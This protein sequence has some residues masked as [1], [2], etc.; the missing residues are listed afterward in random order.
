MLK[1]CITNGRSFIWITSSSIGRNQ[2]GV[3]LGLDQQRCP[4]RA[5]HTG[6]HLKS[7]QDAQRLWTA[8]RVGLI[9]T[10]Q[11]QIFSQSQ[12][13]PNCI[14][15]H[16]M[17][18]SWNIWI[19]VNIMEMF[20]V[21]LAFSHLSRLLRCEHPL[22]YTISTRWRANKSWERKQTV[23]NHKIWPKRRCTITAWS[24]RCLPSGF[25]KRLEYS[26]NLVFY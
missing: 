15:G 23:T 20:R 2:S 6:R 25:C 4:R 19:S 17:K 26:V 24:Q 14:L 11:A 3:Y 5:A 16:Q 13:N 21:R 7:L 22:C 1:R 9:L 18:Q 12:L 10:T 8:V